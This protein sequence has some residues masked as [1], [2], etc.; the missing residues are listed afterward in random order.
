MS[1]KIKIFLLCIMAV[2]SCILIYNLYGNNKDTI[3][4]TDDEIKFKEEYEGL[5]N[6]LDSKG[7]QYLSVD[8]DENNGMIYATYDEIYEL[9]TKGTGIIYFGFPQCPW[10]RNAVPML[11]QATSNM[12]IDN[13]YYFNALDIRDVKSLDSDGNI[14]VEKEGTKEYYELINIL[15]NY[16]GEYEGLNDKNIKRLYFPTV[17][18]VLDG[19]IMGLHVSTIDSQTDPRTP[20]TEKQKSELVQIYMDYIGKISFDV[21]DEKC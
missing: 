15:S 14:V 9:L 19:E 13:I 21:C 7:R 6:Q 10:C 1:S 16:L 20:L 2:V 8:I 4:I 18:F 3:D 5:N 12:G 17:V 11:L